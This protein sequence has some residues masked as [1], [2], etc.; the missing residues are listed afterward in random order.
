M[1][2]MKKRLF[3]VGIFLMLVFAACQPM[4][5]RN[6]TSIVIET[7]VQTDA[8]ER[9][10]PT[11]PNQETVTPTAIRTVLA[12]PTQASDSTVTVQIPTNP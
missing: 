10:S 8:I 4:V 1:N 2:P 11:V 6:G 5:E 3:L 12:E 7:P 9:S